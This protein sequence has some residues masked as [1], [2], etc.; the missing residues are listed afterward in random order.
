MRMKR[1]TFPGQGIIYICAVLVRMV[2]AYIEKGKENMQSRKN[3][4]M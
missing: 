2:S 4:K 3:G 1:E